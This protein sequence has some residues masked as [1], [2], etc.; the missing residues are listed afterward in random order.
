MTHEYNLIEI[1]NNTQILE[2][3]SPNYP[4]QSGPGQSCSYKLV[5]EPGSQISVNFLDMD[6]SVDGTQT[7]TDFV[8]LIE[9]QN[10]ASALIG[11]S[12]RSFCGQQLPNYPG[13]SV[14]ISGISNFK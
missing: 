9:E 14:L 8:E 13:P 7:C 5:S 12:G 3:S 2:I 6:L 4:L 10:S 11:T 1:L